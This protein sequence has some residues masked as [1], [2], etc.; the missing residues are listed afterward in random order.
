MRHPFESRPNPGPAPLGNVVVTDDPNDDARPITIEPTWA[1]STWADDGGPTPRDGNE[2]LPTSAPVT[3]YPG[4]LQRLYERHTLIA[5]GRADGDSRLVHLA[6]IERLAANR[7]IAE[8]EG[9]TDLALER[10]AG[11]GRLQLRGVP[12]AGGGRD[13][14]PDASPR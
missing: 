5:T 9:W 13:V 4:P 11:M 10:V 6:I 7:R 1:E 8:G 14:V 12:P 3:Y 2:R